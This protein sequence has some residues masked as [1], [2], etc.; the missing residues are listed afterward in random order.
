M[1]QPISERGD[2]PVKVLTPK[3]EQLAPS[4]R[5]PPPDPQRRRPGLADDRDRQER[6][7]I[8]LERSKD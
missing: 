1:R 3:V 6:E 2:G 7:R 8:R 5:E 4:D